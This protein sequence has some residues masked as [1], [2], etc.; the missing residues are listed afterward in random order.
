MKGRLR[1]LWT[2][3]AS[4][5]GSRDSVKFAEDNRASSDSGGRPYLGGHC[6]WQSGVCFLQTDLTRSA[7]VN[8]LRGLAASLLI[9]SSGICALDGGCDHACTGGKVGID[10]YQRLPGRCTRCTR[11]ARVR[12]RI[13]A[14]ARPHVYSI[15]FDNFGVPVDSVCLVRRMQVRSLILYSPPRGPLSIT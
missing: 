1:R 13:V 2:R 15:E 7:K 11:L 3:W 5:A 4:L 8:G 10:V 9:S 14:V 12:E 6:Q